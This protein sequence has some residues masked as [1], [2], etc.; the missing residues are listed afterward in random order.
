MLFRKNK[1]S[2]NMNLPEKGK[3]VIATCS[4][5]RTH[6]VF[7]CNCSSPEC[8]AWRDSINGYQVMIDVI[9]WEYEN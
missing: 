5:G 7:R 1:K 4:E 8:T 2:E 3:D 6:Y 9:S